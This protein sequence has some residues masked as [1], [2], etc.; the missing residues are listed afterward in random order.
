MPG[1]L[2]EERD[3]ATERGKHPRY[4]PK[5]GQVLRDVLGAVIGCFHPAKA[6]PL[7]SRTSSNPPDLSF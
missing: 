3:G 4:V 1:C 5:R 7:P 2:G 6:R